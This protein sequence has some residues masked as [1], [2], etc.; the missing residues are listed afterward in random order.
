[1]VRVS[2]V[3][4]GPWS[5]WLQLADPVQGQHPQHLL[6]IWPVRVTVRVR[7]RVR[8]RVTVRVWVRVRVRVWVSV[9]VRVGPSGEI[10]PREG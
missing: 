1:M 8:V 6:L 5:V 10:A 4:V 9:K 2:R 7:V 3:R